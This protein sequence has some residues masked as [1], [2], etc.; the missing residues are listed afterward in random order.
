MIMIKLQFLSAPARVWG[1]DFGF[2]AQYTD[3]DEVDAARQVT[4]Q[5]QGSEYRQDTSPSTHNATCLCSF[6]VSVV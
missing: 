3:L 6:K 5:R 4:R 2:I 1:E